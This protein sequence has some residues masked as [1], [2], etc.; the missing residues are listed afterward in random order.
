MHFVG[1]LE[2]NTRRR[3]LCG[4]LVCCGMSSRE[5]ESPQIPGGHM[6]RS[7]S[8]AL[9]RS[10]SVAAFALGGGALAYGCG[11]SSD[12]STFGG[13]NGG[14]NGNLFGGN[15]GDDGGAVDFIDAAGILEAGC[16]Q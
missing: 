16:A 14:D 9:L 10:L 11:G 3:T 8:R 6:I 13:K 2:P 5:D 15:Q 4:R 1:D 12:D 7:P